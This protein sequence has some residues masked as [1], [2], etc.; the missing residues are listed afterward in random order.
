MYRFS[1]VNINVAVQTENGLYV[2]VVKVREH[3]QYSYLTFHCR[4]F[5]L[6]KNS[7]YQFA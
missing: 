6:L 7:L 3:S 1:N 5:I 2:P 4:K